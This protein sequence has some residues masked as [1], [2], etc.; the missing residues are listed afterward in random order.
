MHR[1]LALLA[2]GLSNSFAAALPQDRAAPE[3]SPEVLLVTLADE[4]ITP[5]VARFVHRAL[6]SARADG[7]A[8][9]VLVLDT[10]GGLVDSTR[11]VVKDI[12]GS[13]APVIVYV[14]PSGARA[15]SGGMFLLLAAHVAAMAP[16]THLGAAHP[17]ALGGLPIAP[18][19]GSPGAQPE[20][21]PSALDSKIVNDT[22]AW[23][24]ALAQLRGR[25]ADWAAR[26][27]SESITATA[28]EALAEQVIDLT[29]PNVEDLLSQLD[30]RM[31]GVGPQAVRLETSGARIR[32]LEMWW[33]ERLLAL[34]ANPNVA[35]LLLIFGF[36]AILFELYTSTWGVAGTLGALAIILAFFGLA[37]LPIN[38]VG[39]LLVLAG[40]GLFLAE[41]FVTSHGLVALAGA[42]C[43]VLGAVMLVDSPLGFVRVSLGVVVP[44]AAAS[45]AI[46]LF[47]VTGVVR[48]HRRRPATGAEGMFR[49]TALAQ[50]DFEAA[51]GAHAG[52][53]LA[54]GELWNAVS[55]QPVRRGQR[56][57]VAGRSGLTLRVT[58]AP[59]GDGPSAA[60]R[61]GG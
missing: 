32:T 20:S 18:E 54:H 44:V 9:V 16:G 6:E 48:A 60:A 43:L 22:V 19:P 33:G 4:A 3:T 36:Y 13:P 25:N 2:V 57:V 30:G 40:L 7:V 11:A 34:I 37:V 35:F 59:D 39:L 46:T 51:G 31:L 50:E 58:A 26:A 28:S 38:S 12:L 5:A 53:V 1:S 29:A 10:P 61:A 42:A 52:R 41:A 24:R 17:V 8:C 27:V 45:A 21:A 14:S 47:L 49:E 56:L 15:A 23:A 55:E